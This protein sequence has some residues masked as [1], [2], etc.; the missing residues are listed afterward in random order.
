M[1]YPKDMT[2]ICADRIGPLQKHQ[3]RTLQKSKK[4]TV[5][6]NKNYNGNGNGI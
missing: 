6:N 4:M 5:K 1:M 2:Y 3:W